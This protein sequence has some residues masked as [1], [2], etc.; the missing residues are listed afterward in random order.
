[1][2]KL[3]SI[4]ALSSVLF[5]ASCEK[6]EVVPNTNPTQPVAQT[7]LEILQDGSWDMVHVHIVVSLNDTILNDDFDNTPGKVTFMVN[8]KL[9]FAPQGRPSDTVDYT[10]Y[11]DSIAFDDAM[12]HIITLEKNQLIL[13]SEEIVND[14][15]DTTFTFSAITTITLKR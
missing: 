10:F 2:K 8:N 6:D 1:M 14:P 7:K 15:S 12:Y 3:T 9:I 5:F 13:E 11:G 4:L